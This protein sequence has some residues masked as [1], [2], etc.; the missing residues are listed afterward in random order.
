MRFLNRIIG[1]LAVFSLLTV[2]AFAQS[3]AS[4]RKKELESVSISQ[5]PLAGYD[6]PKPGDVP[7]PT[8]PAYTYWGHVYAIRDVDTVRGSVDLGFNVHMWFDYRFWANDG[9]EITK[10]GGRSASHVA[11]GYK[12]RDLLVEWLG[13]NQKFPKTAK[14]HQFEKPIQVVVKSVK[15]DKYAERWLYVVYKDGV[16]LNQ[17]AARSGCAIV[18]TFKTNPPFYPRNTPITANMK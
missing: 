7:G 14:Y 8:E 16:S 1:A 10:S 9:F 5:I 6:K 18:T 4:I 2:S 11:R 3:N 17:L 12:C 15:P 13:S